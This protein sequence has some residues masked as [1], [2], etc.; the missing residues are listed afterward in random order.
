VRNL[1]PAH[2]GEGRVRGLSGRTALSRPLPSAEGKERTTN[3]R[4][5]GTM[6]MAQSN[7]RVEASMHEESQL[8]IPTGESRG[9]R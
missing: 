8:S 7:I 3:D 4:R 5:N 9:F 2:G 6:A 1:A